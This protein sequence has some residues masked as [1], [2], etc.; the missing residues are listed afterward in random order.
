MT[1]WERRSSNPC[2]VARLNSGSFSAAGFVKLF[3]KTVM[4]ACK[5]FCPNESISSRLVGDTLGE[6]DGVVDFAGDT[7]AAGVADRLGDGEGDWA[8][9]L[10]LITIA[11]VTASMIRHISRL[12]SCN[13]AQSN[14]AAV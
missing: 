4:A 14:I 5:S 9:A 8:M 2:K 1:P 7:I 12:L 13:R 10:A 11:I 3:F 6:G